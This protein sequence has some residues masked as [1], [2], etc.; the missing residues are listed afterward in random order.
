IRIPMPR[1][2]RFVTVT[3]DEYPRGMRW[4]A[5]CAG[6]QDVNGKFV[7]VAITALCADGSE[8]APFDGDERR[9]FGPYRGGVVRLS[10]E[11]DTQ[12]AIGE[13]IETMLSVLQGTQIPSWAALTAT[14]LA[15]VQLPDS[16]GEVIVCTDSDATGK[17]A[18][19]E[20]AR[21]F[22]TEGRRV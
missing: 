2:I 18:S 1:S 3:C 19:E 13:G 20:A 21:R 12:H 7:G 8:K 10:S 6:I 11:L 16:V 22:A 5:L 17:R 4:P 15:H 14:N 9:I